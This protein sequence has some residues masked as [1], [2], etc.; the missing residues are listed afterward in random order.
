[1]ILPSSASNSNQ[2][3]HPSPHLSLSTSQE[4]SQLVM[5]ADKCLRHVRSVDPTS[6]ESHSLSSVIVQ[7]SVLFDIS[8]RPCL[9]ALTVGGSI[10]IQTTIRDRR[11]TRNKD[12]I[13]VIL[14]SGWDV[15]I[16]RESIY[17]AFSASISPIHT[18]YWC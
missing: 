10:L 9:R 15:G 6:Q 3:E 12:V 18:P 8:P 17:L 14:K 16:V 1:M 7:F 5:V 2:L 11:I 13:D 4:H